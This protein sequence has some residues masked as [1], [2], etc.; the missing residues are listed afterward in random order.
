MAI[1]ATLST[2]SSVDVRISAIRISI[3]KTKTKEK[4]QF[5]YQFSQFQVH[6]LVKHNKRQERYVK[7]ES[8][9][10]TPAS[11]QYSY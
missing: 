4:R 6:S 2:P 10:A 11:I 8:R 7:Q 9:R 1:T 3:G 5:F